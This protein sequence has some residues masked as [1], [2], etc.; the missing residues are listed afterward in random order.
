MFPELPSFSA[1]EAFLFALGRAGG[2]CDCRTEEDDDGSLGSEA[3]GWPFFGQF[4]AHDI[5]ADRSTIRHHVDAAALTNARTPQLNLECLYGDG[6]I[7]Q[8]FLF[9]RDDA[10]KL[11]LS[12]D[13]NDVQRNAEGTA[14]IGDPR[15]DSHVF[16]S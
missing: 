2:L 3:A 13:A 9:R 4:I 12:R 11:L 15:N 7:G 5:T 6:P 10:A 16:M 1:D 8:P 14:I